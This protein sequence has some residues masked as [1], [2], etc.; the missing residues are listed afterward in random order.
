MRN[1]FRKNEGRAPEPK[2]DPRV[3][4]LKL[5]FDPTL[6]AIWSAPADFNRA[7]RRS[8]KLWGSIWKWDAKVLGL[9]NIPPR[10]IR[11]HFNQDLLAH[12]R[13]RRE[14]R[15]RARILRIVKERQL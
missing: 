2:L 8:V 1:P 14:R 7:A 13:T 12:A 4:P 11:R 3:F 9:Q 6:K 5:D 15:H 10:Y